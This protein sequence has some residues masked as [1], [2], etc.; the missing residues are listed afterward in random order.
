MAQ[1]ISDAAVISDKYQVVDVAPSLPGTTFFGYFDR[2]IENEFGE[3][4]VINIVQKKCFLIVYSQKND[5]LCKLSLPIFNLQQGVLATW[6]NVNE[7]IFNTVNRSVIVA[8]RYNIRTKTSFYYDFP[9]QAISSV[10]SKICSIDIGILKKVRGEYSYPMCQD[11]AFVKNKGQLIIATMNGKVIHKL[12][13]TSLKQDA[14]GSTRVKNF[15]LN[16]CI[17]SPSSRFLIFLARG[18]VKGEKQHVLM[19]LDC[20]TNDTY[21]LVTDNVVSHYNWLSEDLIVYWGTQGKKRSYHLIDISSLN[22]VAVHTL[23]GDF[24]DD[25]HPSRIS[26][27]CFVTDTYPD[28][29]RMSSLKKITFDKNF[30]TNVQVIG[31]FYQPLKF[32]G[33]Y[34]VDL[35]PRVEKNG[36]IYFDSGHSGQRRLYKVKKYK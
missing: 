6:V 35:H 27:S 1:K 31:R 5:I 15:K 36:D 26:E 21:S 28:L 13:Y 32:Q 11:S 24:V 10:G 22:A 8:C 17:F 34:R 9:F 16:H 3:F 12:D 7:I 18:W 19:C 33:S 2:R 29:Q 25:G 23:S 14:F 4:I 20:V 30:N